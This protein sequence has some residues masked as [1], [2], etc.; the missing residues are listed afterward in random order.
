L[1]GRIAAD[2]LVIASELVGGI[3]GNFVDSAVA[4]RENINDATERRRQ[5]GEIPWSI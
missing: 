3:F 2:V 5:R 1:T 4:G